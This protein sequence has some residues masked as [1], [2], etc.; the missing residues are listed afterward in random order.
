MP[1]A[2]L[3]PHVHPRAAGHVE[4]GQEQSPSSAALFCLAWRACGGMAGRGCAP[5]R[6]GFGAQ[7][8]DMPLLSP[9]RPTLLPLS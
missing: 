4:E 7:L 9:H 6:A 1:R 2:M 3:C 8:G 5:R